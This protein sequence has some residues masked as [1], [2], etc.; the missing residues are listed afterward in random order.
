MIDRH[1]GFSA[2][3]EDEQMSCRISGCCCPNRATTT[4]AITALGGTFATST[5]TATKITTTTN[6][7]T[8]FELI[9]TAASI[10]EE[11]TFRTKCLAVVDSG[12][13]ASPIWA[14]DY[15]G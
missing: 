8:K 3:T 13:Y 9:S 6:T 15:S 12:T 11:G 14:A 1:Q 7:T 2:H 5:T 10:G 4:T